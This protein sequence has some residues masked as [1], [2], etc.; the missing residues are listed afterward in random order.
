MPLK[1]NDQSLQIKFDAEPRALQIKDCD[2]AVI[3]VEIDGSKS[4]LATPF[5]KTFYG[6]NHT[7]CFSA[8][9]YHT[10]AYSMVDSLSLS[11]KLVPI[12]NA[13]LNI[14]SNPSDAGVYING[15]YFG[16]TPLKNI[17]Y[18]QLYDNIAKEG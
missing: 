16:Q 1:K 14:F 12:E 6:S 10:Q 15:K 13:N 5:E 8:E 7:V 11:L 9:G 18:S 2:P 3:K 17:D 4:T